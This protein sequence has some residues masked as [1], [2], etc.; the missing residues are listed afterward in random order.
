M[1]K[2]GI[3]TFYYKNDNYGGVAQAYALNKYLTNLG[4]DSE[5]ITYSKSNNNLKLTTKNRT[6]K[7]F[8]K[9]GK[10]KFV[11]KLIKEPLEKILGRSINEELKERA[12]KLDIFRE[13]INHSEV[14]NS[15]TITNIKGKY[16]Y[17]ITGSDQT[18]NPGSVDDSYV[19]NFLNEKYDVFSYAPS[20]A[21]KEFSEKY[22]EYMKNALSKY[23][24][25]SVREENSKYELEKILKRD[26][27]WVVD[28][29]MLIK[30]EDWNALASKR[31][32]QEKYVFSYVLGESRKQRNKVKKFAK[33]KGLK[34]VTVPHI[35]HGCKF[36]FKIEDYKFG[37]Y[38]MLDISFED[39]L[40]LI[41]YSEY[42]ITDS[43]HAVSF[44][45]IFEKNFFVINRDSVISMNS[46]IDSIL[47]ILGLPERRIQSGEIPIE[48]DD[49]NYN[50]V[51]KSANKMINQSKE[52]LKNA[53]GIKEGVN[54][55]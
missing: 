3:I 24:Y 38:Q 29:T 34:L 49:I 5:M 9:R 55:E 2:I 30:K 15:E 23:K 14:H 42:V 32:I 44:S 36:Q 37:D 21:V 52:Y 20:V 39:F 17:Y 51:N 31:I 1:K 18:W 8:I 48:E 46:R 28:P 47:K 54:N 41:K 19:Y 35:K 11:N 53:L 22:K 27:S 10:R 40:S 50:D 16:D 33:E 13:K 12:N 45:Y 7:M 4:F 25:I 43:F 26:I 6:I